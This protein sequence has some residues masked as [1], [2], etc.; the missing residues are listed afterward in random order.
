MAQTNVQAFSGDVAISSNLAVD[1]NTLFVDSVG[2]KVG[3]G[4][5]SPSSQLELYGAGKDLTFKYDTSIIRVS[6][7]TRDAYYSGLENSIKR[8]G[9]RNMFDGSVFT[10]DTTH[11]ILMGFSDTYTQ[12]SGNDEYYPSYNE[13]R[14]KLWSPSSSTV[15]SLT[16]IM[17][18]RGNGN[19]GIGTTTP[20][21]TLHVVTPGNNPILLESSG[22][23]G[24]KFYNTEGGA[25]NEKIAYINY[26]H[27]NRGDDD[28]ALQFYNESS[29]GTRRAF[30][31]LT[32]GSLNRLTIL[33][34]GNVGIGTANPTSNL[35]VVG[36]AL[37]TGNVHIDGFVGTS[38][39]GGLIIPSGTTGELPSG[40]SGMIRYNTGLSKLQ[41]FNGSIWLT[42]GGVSAIGGT[43]TSS[44]GYT[45]HTFT[46]SGTLTVVSGGDV[47]YLVVAGGGAGGYAHG[48]G[49]GA[50]GMRTGTITNLTPGTYTIT[51]GGG[52]TYATTSTGGNGSDSTALGLTATGGGG[53][54]KG[55]GSSGGAVGANG[56]SGGSGGG[57]GPF[58]TG[59]AGTS[60]QGNSGGNG[61]GDGA[62]AGHG[63][64]GGGAGGAGGNG[65]PSGY[66]GEGVSGA[67]GNGLASSITGTSVTYAGGGSGGRWG[68]T[69]SGSGAV[70]DVGTVSGG[71]GLGG[72][73]GAGGQ[74]STAGT[75]NT[76][77]GGGGGGDAGGNGGNGGT[78][79]VI[80]RYLA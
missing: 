48:G 1:T 49:A 55:Y 11:E 24:I 29:S 41:V 2:N 8:V 56:N 58:H 28:E 78:G 14:F 10:P 64:G 17:T 53:G 65:I 25:G 38:S 39:T 37:I 43:I 59:A 22:N 27:G 71:G 6:A 62:G 45:I 20:G 23:P 32:S 26:K 21:A 33:D 7:A 40:V 51:Q 61:I 66:A 73:S 42:I 13:M 31:F 34:N 18:L 72:A 76:G 63:G 12:W 69:N 4:T 57:G 80:I 3:I 77:G 35:H 5:T 9:D 15:G 60:G 54:G 16:D 68:G 67:G 30:T 75:A 70:G 50:G 52:G 46:S 74:I 47:E 36:D 19:V 79:I 44:A